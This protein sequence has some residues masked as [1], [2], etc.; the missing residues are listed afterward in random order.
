[1]EVM[2][3][4][5]YVLYNIIHKGLISMIHLHKMIHIHNRIMSIAPPPPETDLNDLIK[6]EEGAQRHLPLNEEGVSYE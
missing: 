4:L 3:A 6:F 5:E 1:M 2:V